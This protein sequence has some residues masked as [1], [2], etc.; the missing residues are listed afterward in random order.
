MTVQPRTQTEIEMIILWQLA[1]LMQPNLV[2]HPRQSPLLARWLSSVLNP[3]C[4]R[5]KI[6]GARLSVSRRLAEPFAGQK[7]KFIENQPFCHPRNDGLMQMPVLLPR[8]SAP[9][10]E[11]QR[12]V[13]I[14]VHPWCEFDLRFNDAHFGRIPRRV[15]DFN[16]VAAT[17]FRRQNLASASQFKPVDA[18]VQKRK[19][20]P[21]QYSLGND[22]AI[23]VSSVRRNHHHRSCAPDSARPRQ[24]L[25]ERSHQHR[26]SKPDQRSRV[27]PC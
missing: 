17:L 8:L 6:I 4:R 26:S 5:S 3:I 1:S 20:V 24:L 11:A 16:P 21:D 10:I 12:V 27:Q 19:L 25:R 2:E 23:F 13:V 22:F 15:A 18:R 14:H 9:V 7:P